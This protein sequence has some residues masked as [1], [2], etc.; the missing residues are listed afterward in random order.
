MG[1][2]FEKSPGILLEPVSSLLVGWKRERQEA[3]SGEAEKIGLNL[4]WF[5]FGWL[6]SSSGLYGK[7]FLWTP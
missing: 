1:Q 5:L 3:M 6:G 7:G 2:S 4:V